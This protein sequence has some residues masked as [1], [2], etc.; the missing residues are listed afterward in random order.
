[1]ST[2]RPAARGFTLIELMVVVALLS[3]MMLFAVPSFLQYRRNADLSDAVSNLIIA[4]GNA[5]SAAL[6]S[7]RNAFVQA[8]DTTAGWTSGWFVYVDTNW[9]NQ[10]D[11]GVDDIV[12][13][14]A[15]LPADLSATGS[16]GSTFASGYLL[17]NG[18]GFPRTK[19]GASGN[20]TITLTTDGRST[21]VIVDTSGR[22]RSCKVG[23]A[24]CSAM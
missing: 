23:T 15:A 1:M 5:K 8:N 7:G 9:N 18:A 13:S 3:T 10:Y 11:E 24:G 12:M 22:L 17:F 16:A 19:L 21:N 4:A 14:H 6:K 20:G 2:A